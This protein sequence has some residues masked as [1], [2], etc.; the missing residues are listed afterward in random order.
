[1]SLVCS[2]SWPSSL[3]SEF[4]SK[5]C[6]GAA[7][8]DQK[9]KKQTAVLNRLCPLLENAYKNTKWMLKLQQEYLQTTD[10]RE[11]RHIV[12]SGFAIPPPPL[13]CSFLRSTSR[14]QTVEG[15]WKGRE[16]KGGDDTEKKEAGMG[17]G[18]RNDRW[19]GTLGEDPS[20]VCG[21]EGET[22]SERRREN[23]RETFTTPPLLWQAAG[24]S[25]GEESSSLPFPSSSLTG[26]ATGFPFTPQPQSP[27]AK[28][29]NTGRN[30]ALQQPPPPPPPIQQLQRTTSALTTGSST[31]NAAKQQG[32]FSG[33][34]SFQ[35]PSI[36]MGGTGNATG[37]A[38]RA[39]VPPPP[40]PL[41]PTPPADMSPTNV[42]INAVPFNPSQPPPPSTTP[43]LFSLMDAL[44]SAA[45]RSG[46][47]ADA[48][49][50]FLPTSQS[51]L[52]GGDL[53]V[54]LS[55]SGTELQPPP[56]PPPPP[57]F[58]PGNRQQSAEPQQESM[59]PQSGGAIWS[60]VGGL[61]EV[62]G[63]TPGEERERERERVKKECRE[64]SRA[65]GGGSFLTPSNGGG[66]FLT[67][68][69]G[70]GSLLTPSNGGGSF[71]TPSNGGGSL[72]TP[73]NGGAAQHPKFQISSS[74]G[75]TKNGKQLS[76]EAPVFIPSGT[77]TFSPSPPQSQTN[78]LSAREFSPHDQPTV[79]TTKF[80]THTISQTME[81]PPPPLMSPAPPNRNT[82]SMKPSDFS[83]TSN[84]FNAL[85]SKMNPKVQPPPPPPPP[86]TPPPPPLPPSSNLYPSSDPLQH[87]VP[88]PSH[89]PTGQP[90]MLIPSHPQQPDL[91]SAHQFPITQPT[92]N[93]NL[94]MPPGQQ[95]GARV[96][97]T[98]PPPPPPPFPPSQTNRNCDTLTEPQNRQT[99]RKEQE[100]NTPEEGM[101]HDSSLPQKTFL[102]F[103]I[104]QDEHPPPPNTN[105]T[106]Q[107]EAEKA[108]T[109]LPPSSPTAFKHLPTPKGTSRSPRRK[110]Q[111]A[112]LPLTPSPAASPRALILMK[113]KDEEAAI[114]SCTYEKPETESPA[115]IQKNRNSSAPTPPEGDYER[116]ERIQIPRFRLPTGAQRGFGSQKAFVRKQER[117]AD[118]SPP[119]PNH[120]SCF[121]GS[122]SPPELKK[123]TTAWR[124]RGN[125]DRD[126]ERDGDD[127]RDS[128][129]QFQSS[130]VEE[131]G[132]SGRNDAGRFE[133]MRL[134][135]QRLSL[136]G[137]GG[138]D[139][140][141]ERERDVE[142]NWR[143]GSLSFER[144][145]SSKDR[146]GD[147][148][149][150]PGFE[151]EGQRHS[152]RM[153][154]GGLGDLEGERQEVR[155][156]RRQIEREEADSSSYWTREQLH[157]E[158]V[159]RNTVGKQ[160]TVQTGFVPRKA[161]AVRRDLTPPP[162]FDRLPVS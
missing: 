4:S 96:S 146:D 35:S 94:M 155:W 51:R 23:G 49:P 40:P 16:R 43:P 57:P 127:N 144:R 156:E 2:P 100:G 19:N 65:I 85:A 29:G 103:Q 135:P 152:V 145:L 7:Q 33:G 84:T 121:G 126:R 39:T 22:D 9:H 150:D 82:N 71:L 15:V 107:M 62:D 47:E 143:R 141:R 132:E 68:S 17:G 76:A 116:E 42:N 105:T 78:A 6:L 91:H 140:E 159:E 77:V 110:I 102:P 52:A 74:H 122:L 137:R 38:W 27:W 66:S 3:P 67:P 21:G 123:E 20:R 73:S 11:N 24:L 55:S 59:H 119:L 139:S 161:A 56:P 154:R 5:D 142:R 70:E 101:E 72:L 138:V 106:T 80:N 81:P 86:R 114:A 99:V 104:P 90:K 136:S 115:K 63:E 14:G 124:S 28:K 34:F 149:G 129:R 134:P 18:E 98:P 10:A 133:D 25:K 95:V 87:S 93:E 158:G 92:H 36:S 148:D 8:G 69:N 75:E 157:K 130:Y 153:D 120:H 37:V 162:G 64:D 125:G 117:D 31:T 54:S 46:G 1:M 118:P 13:S 108:K 41:P 112:A 26:L 109:T 97:F 44:A 151:G 30:N 32:N 45:S 131:R 61:R 12:Q 88:L 128:W 79:P 147:R 48:S 83:P 58:P 111:N 89:S 113:K 160:G 60:L 50:S 53:N